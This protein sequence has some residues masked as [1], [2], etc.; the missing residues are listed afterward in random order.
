[1]RRTEGEERG[2]G[3]RGE[4]VGLGASLRCQG[5][6]GPCGDV[7]TA[8]CARLC[9]V[10]VCYVRERERVR[11]SVPLKHSSAQYDPWPAASVYV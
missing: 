4:G 9:L 7:R 1:M 6:P 3:S 10:G 8:V 2:G 11:G 5:I